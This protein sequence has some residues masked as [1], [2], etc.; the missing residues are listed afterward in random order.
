MFGAP[1]SAEQQ[2]VRWG[3]C[4]LSQRKIEYTEPLGKPVCNW[5]SLGL[6]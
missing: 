6:L 1:G 4:Y 5:F 2:Q 3:E